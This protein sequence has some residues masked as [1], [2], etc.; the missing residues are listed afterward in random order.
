MKSNVW[1][2]LMTVNGIVQVNNNKAMQD[3]LKAKFFAPCN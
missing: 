1:R 3:K 2:G